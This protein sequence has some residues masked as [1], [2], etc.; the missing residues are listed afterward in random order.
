MQIVHDAEVPL[1]ARETV[2]TSRMDY[3]RLLFGLPG[4]PGNF[5]LVLVTTYAGYNGPRHRHNFDQIKL[6]L[7][8]FYDHHGIGKQTT[9][10]AA[11]FPEGTYYGPFTSSEKTLLLLLQFGGASGAGFMSDEEYNRSMHALRDRGEYRDGLYDGTGADGKKIRKDAY[12]ATWEHANERRIDYPKPRYKDPVLMHPE[13]FAWVTTGDGAAYKLLGDFSERKTRMG[14]VR[15]ETGAR[16][17]L[18][19]NSV[20]FVMSGRGSAGTDEWLALS[21]MHLERDEELEIVASAAAELFHVRLPDFST[22][23]C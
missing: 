6:Q 15:L 9:G 17:T 20:Y 10:M 23:V 7:D 14:F 13:N 21:S 8:G 5:K 19:G 3:R 18:A 2:R 1:E 11:Y 4:T 16:T 22:T 12:E